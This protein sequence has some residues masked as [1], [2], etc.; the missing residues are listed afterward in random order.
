MVHAKTL[1]E[2]V[3]HFRDDTKLHTT[4]SFLYTLQA[5]LQLVVST[6]ALGVDGG[7]Y[8]HIVSVVNCSTDEL[9]S[10]DHKF[11]RC[12][13][14]L[15]SF[16]EKAL[17][18]FLIFL[19]LYC[20]ACICTIIRLMSKFKFKC[21]LHQRILTTI[22]IFDEPISLSTVPRFVCAAGDLAFFLHL[23][24]QHNKLLINRFSVFLSVTEKEKKEF[25]S[26]FIHTCWCLS[27]SDTN[28][29]IEPRA[30]NTPSI[31]I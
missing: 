25:E 18:C 14:A 4:V 9:I 23:L 24:N 8:T 16:Y 11:F 3:K 10:V 22:Y 15:A 5:F 1:Y 28:K 27:I 6:V 7:Y 29:D 26:R 12:Y 21:L 2:K 17:V 13:D 19:A 30:P 20:F 31:I